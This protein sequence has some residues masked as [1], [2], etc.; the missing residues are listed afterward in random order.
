VLNL[1]T[2]QKISDNK[3]LL[4]CIIGLLVTALFIF[5]YR[6]LHFSEMWAF[7]DL[8][9]FPKDITIIENWTFS[10]W[11]SQGLGFLSFKPFTYYI[12]MLVSTT[13]LGDNLA[14]KAMF[15][16]LPIFSFT[17]FLLFLR[18]LKV[19]MFAAI[20][21]SLLYAV[22][23]VTVSEFVG[24]SMTL[25][26]Y[27]TFPIILLFII[28]ILNG[29]EI[30]IVDL[31][32]LGLSS[33]FVLNVHAAFWYLIVIVPAIVAVFYSNKLPLVKATKRLTRLFIPLIIGLMIIFPNVLGYIGLYGSTA[34]TD[35]TF[36]PDTVYCYHDSYFYNIVRL[37]GNKGSVQAEEYLN[38]NTINNYTILGY[39]IPLIAFA[40][41]LIKKRDSSN[42]KPLM[43]SFVFAFLFGF[44]IISMLRAFPF[45][46]DLHPILASLRNPVKLM[47]PIAFSLCFLFTIGT[48]KIIVTV[49]AKKRGQVLKFLAATLLVVIILSYNYPAIEGTLGV[50][51]PNVRGEDYYVKEKYVNLPSTLENLDKNYLNYRVMILPWELSTLERVSS[52]IPNYFGMPPGTAIS[53]DINWMQDVFEFV[54]EEN[55]GDRGLLLGLFEVKYI[56]I[57]KTFTSLFDNTSVYKSLMNGKSNMVYRA[58]DSFWATGNP[59]YYAKIFGNDR[60]F[61][62]VH[63][64]EN[65]VIFENKKALAK[66]HIREDPINLTFST[67]FGSE[68]L[69]KNPSF[70]NGLD[71]WQFGPA[72][73]VNIRQ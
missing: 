43:L 46:V 2:K 3:I 19:N 70:E 69:I 18:K 52:Y 5:L 23:P 28:R 57:D 44:F 24:G 14:Q 60:D 35:V 32:V 67:T 72:D 40:P 53:S 56:V 21:G 1:T 45:A 41:L 22:N 64:D 47:Y 36:V 20:V 30:N 54:T 27:A 55:S 7:G 9:A 39:A 68:N 26:A 66:I 37:A 38:Y 11:S 25:A 8:S 17:T 49:Q 71:D 65:F 34:T 6:N 12:E 58:H 4:T 63:E 15:L 62:M 73:K 13:L 33:F 29:K 61:S 10:A 31:I 59:T 50:G 51:L 48:Q 16:L 42:F